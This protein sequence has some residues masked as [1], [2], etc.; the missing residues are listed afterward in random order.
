MPITPPAPLAFPK[1]YSEWIRFFQECLVEA[2]RVKE[3]TVAEL[4]EVPRTNRLAFVTDETDGYVLAFR[5][6]SDVWRRCTD[7]AVCS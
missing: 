1:D 3:Y 5:D 6:A 2:S 4:S 7:R